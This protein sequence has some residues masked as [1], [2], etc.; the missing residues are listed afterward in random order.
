MYSDDAD[1]W[2]LPHVHISN[3]QLWS[4]M[5]EP[6]ASEMQNLLSA[7]VT[8]LRNVI[9]DYSADGSQVDLV[10]ELENHSADWR[11]P[12][13]ATWINQAALNSLT[14]K[15][16]RHRA[17][18]EEA[19]QAA[20]TGSVPD[21]RPRWERIGWFEA[22]STWM[23]AQLA[24]QD[25]DLTSPIVQVKS[26]GISCLLRASTNRGDVFFKVSSSLPLFGNEPA[27]MKALAGRYPAYVPAPISIEPEQR[28]M[29]M[30]DFGTELRAMSS[31]ERWISAI[32]RFGTLQVQAAG[33][34]EDLLAVG[35]LDRRLDILAQQIDPLLNDESVLDL[36]EEDGIAR[37]HALAPRLKAMCG[38]LADY[39]V[40]P[41]L[42]HGDLHSGNITGQTL[43]F[44]D[45]TDACIAHPFLDL[46]TVMVDIRENFPAWRGQVLD[47]YLDLWTAYEPMDR[48]REMWRLAEPLGA[49]HQAVS[50]QHIVATLE[51]S[52][53]QEMVSGVQRWLRRVIQMMPQ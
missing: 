15:R 22:A 49:L 4:P 31:A 38:T 3:R 14:L 40:R 43:Q 11:P 8:V 30:Q 17:L 2:S 23:Q 13:Q 41:S 29:L 9:A 25:Y 39:H 52:S 28:W 45:W 32:Q 33:V 10:Y 12:P 44:F 37:L 53:R 5:V 26:W 6:V 18:I 20:Q 27:L 48:L 1:T 16:P 36:L 51:P 34:I 24:D 50:Y 21:L 35:C 19:L 42:S 7:N 47:A 46:V